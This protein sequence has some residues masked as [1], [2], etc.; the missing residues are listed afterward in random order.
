ML[1]LSSATSAGRA[2]V[3]DQWPEGRVQVRAAAEPVLAVG[4][5]VSAS[6]LVRGQKGFARP[7]QHGALVGVD[8]VPDDRDAALVELVDQPRI[9]K[10]E[11]GVLISFLL[12]GG[13]DR[14]SAMAR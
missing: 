7:T 2:R 1:E 5:A 9:G 8:R 6:R 11:D 3:G 4:A 13:V 12:V 14:S 10:A